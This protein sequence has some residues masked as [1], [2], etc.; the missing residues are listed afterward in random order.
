MRI[1]IGKFDVTIKDS[2]T[3]GEVQRV[4]AVITS[5]ARIGNAGLQGFDTNAMLEA[6]YTLLETAITQ[7]AEG[8]TEMPFT[9]EWMNGLTVDEGDALYEAVDALTKKK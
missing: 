1:T 4:Q 5:G 9:R 3:W 6:K 8:E 7:I 2:L